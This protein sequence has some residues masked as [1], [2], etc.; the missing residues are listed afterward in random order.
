MI[1]VSNSDILEQCQKYIASYKNGASAPFLT[2][3]YIAS[4]FPRLEE[5]AN[6]IRLK[7]LQKRLGKDVQSVYPYEV[8]IAKNIDALER[9][10]FEPA[11]TFVLEEPIKGPYSNMWF[12][13]TTEGV[14]IRWGYINGDSRQITTDALD[15]TTPHG[16]LG[17]ATGQGKSVTLNA[18]IYGCC[19]E[20][21]P[22]ELTL[23]LCDAKIV[24]FKNIA[25]SHPMP[26]IETVA[27]TSDTDY[28]LSL[29]ELKIREMNRYNSVY[30]KAG[31]VLNTNIANI[32]DFRRATGLVVPRNVIVFDEVTA[33]FTNAG[34]R[35]NQLA[36]LIDEFARLGRNTGYHI[37]LT[38]QEI[39]S[40]LPAPTL[41]NMALR[42]AMGCDPEVSQRIIGNAAAA[43]NKGVKGQLIVNCTK[44]ERDNSASNV[45]VRVPFM[46]PNQ[47]KEISGGI[48]QRGKE[49]KFSPRLRFFDGDS[50]MYEEDFVKFLNSLEPRED[51]IVLGPP[52]F[53]IEHGEQCVQ[54]P[55]TMRDNESIWVAANGEQAKLRAL[56]LLKHNLLRFKNDTHLAMLVDPLYQEKGGVEQLTDKR[57][58]K[59]NT[60]EGSNFINLSKLTIYRRKLCVQADDIV[61]ST[62][63]ENLELTDEFFY[64]LFEKGSP[65][66]TTINRYRIKVYLS[67]LQNDNVLRAGF[68]IQNVNN[69]DLFTKVSV[70][71]QTC[72]KLCENSGCLNKKIV[73][74]DFSRVFC[75]IFG[76]ERV[77]G[78]GRDE[79]SKCVDA[80]KKLLQDCTAV[81]V[82]F[83]VF[84][85]IYDSIGS[86]KDYVGAYLLEDIVDRQASRIGCS[87]WPTAPLKNAMIKFSY[88]GEPATRMQKFLKFLLEG[89]LPS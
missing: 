18:F 15:D 59:E 16:F 82:R 29:L 88:T 41:A 36:T 65:H 11:R 21:P 75:W 5:R 53:I 34:R 23:S 81:N 1:T 61:F 44:S 63:P 76:M 12:G 77:L 26:H 4:A 28:I 14:N 83:V 13:D 56:A 79:R 86:F 33:M 62:T 31:G 67:L 27:A 7:N 55:L 39:S 3:D 6:A 45:A 49:M 10:D 80:F 66:D 85:G 68:G 48:I 38:S 46:P 73:A 22:W 64:K 78:I 60:Y 17:G 89:E 32:K 87:D 20:Y 24:E 8:R 25:I 40:D 51:R 47:V 57:L 37:L 72:L 43:K 50:A 42:A 19:M 71:L 69:S 52:S 9:F 30:T 35:A 74:Q 54:L 84:S 58:Y 2:S 70:T